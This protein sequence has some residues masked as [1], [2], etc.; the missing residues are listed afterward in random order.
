MCQILLYMYTRIIICEEI[1]FACLVS[2]F[3]IKYNL[4]RLYTFYSF[5]CTGL[6]DTQHNT[7]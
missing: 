3:T 4:K 2:F 5:S 1:S 7:P 6:N